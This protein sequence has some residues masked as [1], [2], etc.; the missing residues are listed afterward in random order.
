LENKEANA[1]NTQPGAEQGVGDRLKTAREERG[2]TQGAVAN[3]T[4][5]IDPD[6]KGISR[7]AIIGYEQGTSKP[8]LR[9]IK[10]LCEILLISP[11]WLIYGTESAAVVSQP[12]MELLKPSTY[13]EV[14]RLLRTAFALMALKGHERDALQSLVLSLAGRQLGDS[15]LSGLLSSSWMM[16][17]AFF[18]AL[19]VYGPEIN[20]DNTLE[21]IAESLSRGCRTNQGTRFKFDENGEIL[22]ETIGIY[23]DP[24]LDKS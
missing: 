17:D 20:L 1:A 24:K 15:R 9:E 16:R 2:F 6:M 5:G 3:R 10:L 14:D 4:K 18:D 11:N 21:E 8:G 13:R 23:S 7:T 22:N 12:S 19:T